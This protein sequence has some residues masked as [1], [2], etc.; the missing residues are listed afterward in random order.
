MSKNF[1][2]VGMKTT[3]QSEIMTISKKRITTI[4]DLYKV[5]IMLKN[6]LTEPRKCYTPVFDRL[7]G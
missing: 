4:E 1:A 2:V 7:V 6:S 5:I 3:I